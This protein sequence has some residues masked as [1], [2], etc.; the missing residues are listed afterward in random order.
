MN[1]FEEYMYLLR[2]LHILSRKGKNDTKEADIIRDKMDLPYKN[3][4]EEQIELAKNFSKDLNYFED[5]LLDVV[6]NLT[7]LCNISD[8][9]N[10]E[11]LFPKGKL[12]TLHEKIID[13][14]TKVNGVLNEH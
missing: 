9:N 10:E 1:I 3:L 5:I 8:P 12:A 11:Q 2:K 14:Y 7:I 4:S 6:V 13:L